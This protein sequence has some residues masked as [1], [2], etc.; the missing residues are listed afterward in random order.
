MMK[1][2]NLEQFSTELAKEK[3]RF[4]K[5]FERLLMR[6]IVEDVLSSSSTARIDLFAIFDGVS[7]RG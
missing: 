1:Q 5:P 3:I 7:K 2:K 6:K 4:Y